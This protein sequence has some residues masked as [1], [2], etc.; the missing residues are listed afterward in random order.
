MAELQDNL[1]EVSHLLKESR[2][3]N[4]SLK[5]DVVKQGVSNGEPTVRVYSIQVL[6][7]YPSLFF[8]A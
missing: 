2:E 7:L 4:V 6:Y 1:E 3:E 8:I 5:E